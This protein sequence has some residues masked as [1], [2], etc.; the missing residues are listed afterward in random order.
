MIWWGFSFQDSVFKL[1]TKTKKNIVS[2][3]TLR[4]Y[5]NLALEQKT[6][7]ELNESINSK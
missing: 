1:K 2:V 7:P 5:Q 4:M 6:C 3:F